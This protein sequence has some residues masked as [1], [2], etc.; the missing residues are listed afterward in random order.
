[1]EH[2]INSMTS[3]IRIATKTIFLAAILLFSSCD[4]SYDLAEFD[5]KED[6]R[7]PSAF[8][9]ASV[10]GEDQWNQVDFANGSV[11]ANSYVWDFGDGTETS[12][13]MEPNHS[14]PPIEAEYTVTLTVSDANGLTSVYRKYGEHCS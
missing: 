3:V 9:G 1:M 11:S 10:R 12:T 4:F 14:Y 13:E 7:A 2:N 8:F 5:S 6:L